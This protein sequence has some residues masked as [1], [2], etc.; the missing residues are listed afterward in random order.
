MEFILKTDLEKSL[1]AVIDFNYEQIKSELAI[2]LETYKSLVVTEET[3]KDGK[4]KKAALN[5]LKDALDAQRIAVKKQMM[6][7]YEEFEAKVKSLTSMIKEAV[8]NIDGQ[9]KAFDDIK[10]QEKT[11]EIEKIYQEEIGEY[12]DLIPIEKIWNTK[13]LNVTTSIAS[14]EVE[15][16]TKC[17]KAKNDIKV[18]KAMKSETETTMLS[19][20][21]QKLELSDALAEKTRFEELQKRMAEPKPEPKPTEEAPKITEEEPK[22]DEELKTI[23]VIFYDTTASFRADMK[24]LTSRHNIRYGGI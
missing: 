21:L 12:A 3:I 24:E 14:I 13:W 8:D 11:A 6:Q 7:P 20:F 9:I 15:I 5:S 19:A 22:P 2:N 4:K 10:K 23:K 1:P 17:T 16:S 18:I